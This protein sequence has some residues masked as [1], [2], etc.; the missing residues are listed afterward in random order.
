[1]SIAAD[2]IGTLRGGFAHDVKPAVVLPPSAF[3]EPLEVYP[4]V[5]AEPAT[6]RPEGEVEPMFAI[7]HDASYVV[8]F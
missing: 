6:H 3:D 1:M 7:L 8:T 2:R 4:N 5:P